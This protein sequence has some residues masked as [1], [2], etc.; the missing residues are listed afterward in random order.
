MTSN[1]QDWLSA[2][3]LGLEGGLAEEWSGFLSMLR[4][5]GVTLNSDE[6]NVVWS[7]NKSTGSMT[8][9]LAYDALIT[10]DVVEEPV[11]W[12]KALWKVKIPV[13][14]ILFIWLFLYDCVLTG[15]NY[16]HRGGI[17]PSVCTLCLKAEETTMHLFVHC[18]TTQAIWKEVCEHLKI[19]GTWDRPSL[20][21]NLLSWFISFPRNRAS[22]FPC[23]L[24]YMALQKQNHV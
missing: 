5:S 15:E 21:E 14:I 13:K 20:D 1:T 19:K 11:W 6:D 18:T 16:R 2:E 9:K 24:G 10:Q 4:S 22:T 8:A 3:D 7:W 12:H 17:G 23:A